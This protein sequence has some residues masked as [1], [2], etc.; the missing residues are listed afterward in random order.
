MHKLDWF[1][2][3]KYGAI[4]HWGLYAIPGGVWQGEAAPHGGE[5]IMKNWRQGIPLNDY[6]QLMAQFPGGDAAQHGAAFLRLQ[7]GV[8]ARGGYA[9]VFQG[10]ALVAHECDEW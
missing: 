3:A 1:L 2:R 8:E 7:G 6:K 9:Q 10:F 4:I 5:W